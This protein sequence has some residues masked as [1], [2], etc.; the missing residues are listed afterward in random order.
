MLGELG[1][2]F[3]D[4]GGGLVG[5]AE[6]GCVEVDDGL[7]LSLDEGCVDVDQLCDSGSVGATLGIGELSVYSYL[8]LLSRD[9][10]LSV[11]SQA[12]NERRLCK[13]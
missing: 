10:W 2:V 8:L 5:T 4:L 11:I 3:E 6:G 9:P 7:V 13:L 1:A 12:S